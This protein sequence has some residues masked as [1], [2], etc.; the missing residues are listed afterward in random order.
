[1]KNIRVKL[2]DMEDRYIFKIRVSEEERVLFCFFK[3]G[4]NEIFEKMK[5]GIPRILQN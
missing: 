1:M 4:R 3:A 5:K 2:I